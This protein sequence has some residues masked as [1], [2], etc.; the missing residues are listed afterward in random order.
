[1][2]WSLRQGIYYILDPRAIHYVEQRG[3]RVEKQPCKMTTTFIL[4][5]LIW[6]L[7]PIKTPLPACYWISLSLSKPAGAE[8]SNTI[9]YGSDKIRLLK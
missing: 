5:L 8:L 2:K 1:M 9:S 6:K 7:T 3:K 4:Q